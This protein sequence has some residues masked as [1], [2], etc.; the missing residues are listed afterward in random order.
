VLLRRQQW[1]DLDFYIL[2]EAILLNA[3][4]ENP[5]DLKVPSSVRVRLSSEELGSSK[6]HGIELFSDTFSVVDPVA[7]V[8]VACGILNGV[9]GKLHESFPDKVKLNLKTYVE[10]FGRKE[11]RKANHGSTLGYEEWDRGALELELQHVQE[12]AKPMLVMSLN[13][14][15]LQYS[16]LK[17]LGMLGNK[18]V[19]HRE[20]DPGRQLAVTAIHTEFACT[21]PGAGIILPVVDL[22][23]GRNYLEYIEGLASVH[24]IVRLWKR[25]AGSSQGMRLKE[26]M[27]Y[28]R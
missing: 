8:E 6:D 1:T 14:K 26:I 27:Q 5:V 25:G 3:L 19:Q 7:Y 9:I 24:S 21:L 4:G 15:T 12:K 22:S 2:V 16:F 23:G 20:V 18:Y 13:L 17:S 10:R 28:F 11:F